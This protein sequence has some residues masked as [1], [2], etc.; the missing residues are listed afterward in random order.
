[1]GTLWDPSL[2]PEAVYHFFKKKSDWETQKKLLRKIEADSEAM[3]KG[4]ESPLS[5]QFPEEIDFKKNWKHEYD[6]IGFVNNHFSGKDR[7]RY[8]RELLDLGLVLY[9]P[10]QS[11][12]SIIEG[13]LPEFDS[14]YQNAFISDPDELFRICADSKVG[15]NIFHRQNQGG[16]TNFRFNEYAVS[17][18]PILSNLNLECEKIF[19]D[20]VGALY[21]SN[22]T[23]MREQ[24]KRLLEDPSLA[25]KLAGN[26]K[27]ISL[28]YFHVDRVCK[29]LLKTLELSGSPLSHKAAVQ[30]TPIFSYQSMVQSGHTSKLAFVLNPFIRMYDFYLGHGLVT[31]VMRCFTSL[32]TK[33]K[34]VVTNLELASE[35]RFQSKKDL[36]RQ[37]RLPPPLGSLD[38]K[39][40]TS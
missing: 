26:A 20:E 36:Q 33:L 37:K 12:S 21:F 8:L 10:V 35:R 27:K 3:N 18:T 6:Y 7:L 4:L 15:L 17:Q 11:W 24:A 22:T 31:T 2:L 40:S 14:V 32:A 28:D 16:G 39:Q 30:E 38:L 19:P 1:M 13:Y 23:E 5:E 25:V 29:S 34:H 9:G